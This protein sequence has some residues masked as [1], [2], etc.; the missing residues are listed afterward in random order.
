MSADPP[1]VI[2]PQEQVITWLL[3]GH[4]D[5]DV[6][7]SIRARWPGLEPAE[8]STG[9]VERFECA[10]HCHLPIVVGWGLEAYKELYR[11]SLE[12]GD[13]DGA[14]KCIKELIALAAKYVHDEEPDSDPAHEEAG[15]ENGRGA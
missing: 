12:M 2:H 5:A 13:I 9:A 11:R 1:A 3:E 10:G 6:I 8:L 7:E 4:R 15:D 14:R